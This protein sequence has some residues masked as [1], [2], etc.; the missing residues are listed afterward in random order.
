MGYNFFFKNESIKDLQNE[1]E[2]LVRDVSRIKRI[3]IENELPHLK[4]EDDGEAFNGGILS[5]VHARNHLRSFYFNTT[6]ENL[7]KAIDII[8]KVEEEENGL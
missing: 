1:I 4:F 5:K 8:L 7:K 3:L 6:D 2:S